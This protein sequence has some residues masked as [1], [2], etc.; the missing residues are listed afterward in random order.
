[1]CASANDS[2]AEKQRDD[3]IFDLIKRRYDGEIERINNLD[4]KAGNLIGLTGVIAGFLLG[5][6][7]LTASTLSRNAILSIIYFIGIG[8]LLVSIGLALWS[9]RVRKWAAVPD[10]ATLLEKYTNLSYSEV[11]QSNAGEMKK[12][13]EKAEIQNEQKAKLIGLSWYLLISGL[14]L[15]FIFLLISTLSAGANKT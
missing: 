11:L 5:A 7:T 8:I 15:V 14:T 13:V 10:V 9:V 3:L 6:S 4:N 2:D 12:A 1:M